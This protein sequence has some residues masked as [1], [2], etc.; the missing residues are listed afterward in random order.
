MEA[1][2]ATELSE[3]SPGTLPGSETTV[4]GRTIAEVIVAA[5]VV[6]GLAYYSP[7]ETVDADPAIALIIQNPSDSREY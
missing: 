1:V 3:P 6:F 2:R 5:T 7:V 4:A